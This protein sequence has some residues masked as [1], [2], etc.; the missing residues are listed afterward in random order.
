MKN[1][2]CIVRLNPS[3]DEHIDIHTEKLLPSSLNIQFDR[4]KPI[5]DLVNKLDY[6]LSNPQ[7]IENYASKVRKHADQ[8]IWS[9]DERINYEIN[10]L[11]NHRN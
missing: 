9:W 1:G 11:L 10:Q 8:K 3:H 7:E 2:C 5:E 4:N 6:L